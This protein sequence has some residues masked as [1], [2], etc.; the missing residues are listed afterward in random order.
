MKG[1][2]EYWQPYP[3]SDPKLI[4]E[5]LYEEHLRNEIVKGY[6]AIRNSPQH[7]FDWFVMY[8]DPR[9]PPNAGGLEI[10]DSWDTQE[11]MRKFEV[12]EE[13]ASKMRAVHHRRVEIRIEWAVVKGGIPVCAFL[14]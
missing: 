3:G 7:R 12:S 5:Q 10:V 9:L 4:E 8:Q 11:W 13:V 1:L 14:V 2:L 6:K